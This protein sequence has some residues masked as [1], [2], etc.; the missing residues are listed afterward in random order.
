MIYLGPPLFF[1]VCRRCGHGQHEHSANPERGMCYHRSC[2]CLG[3]LG[4]VRWN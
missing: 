1:P 2:S 4:G 3:Y